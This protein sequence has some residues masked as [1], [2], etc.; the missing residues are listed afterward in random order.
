MLI[1]RITKYKN[2]IHIPLDKLPLLMKR[3]VQM[4]IIYCHLICSNLS[5]SVSAG[6]SYFKK[7]LL[8]W[9]AAFMPGLI[10]ADWAMPVT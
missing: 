9:K 10:E 8:I 4:V 5:H 6:K 3:D 1:V 2:A 7:C